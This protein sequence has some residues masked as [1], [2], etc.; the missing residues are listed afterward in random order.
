VLRIT[1]W[2]V[3]FETHESRKLKRLDWVSLPNDLLDLRYRM[4]IE[5]PDGA[6]HFGAWVATIEVGSTCKIRG[7]LSEGGIS[8]T[9]RHLALKSGLPLAL[10]ESAIPRL[11]E[12]G[13]LEEIPDVAVDHAVIPGESP[14]VAADTADTLPESREVT[15]ETS[16][17]IDTNNNS[18]KDNKT[19]CSSADERSAGIALELTPPKAEKPSDDI[20]LWFDLEFWPIYPRKVAKPQAL[21]AARRH[22][23]TATDRAAI[24]ECL[25]R[26]LPSLEA[27]F[28]TDGDF[29]PHPS[30]WLNQEPWLEPE[31]T[32]TPIA[33]TRHDVLDLE[34]DRI[35]AEKEASNS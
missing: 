32:A 28:R 20:K 16:A 23:K 5:H 21:K 24:L 7:T 13:W 30:S 8:L 9:A 6:A 12:I 27:Q 35:L 3:N 4:L 33:A 19:L 22:G 25:N 34:L 2:P 31:E 15:V 29:R 18:N 17:Y 11:L 26:R 14:C 1:K 10:F